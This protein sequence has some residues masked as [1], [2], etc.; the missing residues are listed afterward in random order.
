[1]RA[2]ER[3]QDDAALERLTEHEA[4]LARLLET[5]RGDA[6]RSAA[7]ASEAAIALRVQERERLEGEVA[8]ARL[9]AASA[10]EEELRLL[11]RDASRA[12]E[13]VREQAASRRDAAVS[14]AVE[15]A[16]RGSP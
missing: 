9:A 14:R 12:V 13:L 11:C 8:A 3:R 5:A 6:E 7:R 16:S 1:M 15:A 10:L 4:E 2:P